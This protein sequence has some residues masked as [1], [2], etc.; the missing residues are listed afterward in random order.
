MAKAPKPKQGGYDAAKERQ[1]R[2]KQVFRISLRDGDFSFVY[3][4]SLPVRVRGY[5]RDTTG[6]SV[7]LLLFGSAGNDVAMYADMWWLSRLAAGEQ[8]MAQV[9][10]GKL[11][12]GPL[13][14]ETVMDEFDERCPGARYSDFDEVDISG[15]V[16]DSPEA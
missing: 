6:K 5:V 4:P 3:R 1:E 11:P 15:E 7:D 13:S 2:A 8:E 10:D 16:D 12:V 14:R 9:G